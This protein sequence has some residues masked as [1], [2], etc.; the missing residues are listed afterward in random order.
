MTEQERI[1]ELWN[2]ISDDCA[3]KPEDEC[4]VTTNCSECKAI[5]L[6]KAGYVKLQD[7]EMIITKEEYERYNQTMNP[8]KIRKEVA[9]EIYQKLCGHGTTYVKKWIEKE[10]GME[11]K[12]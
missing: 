12:E 2:F 10:F 1:E 5:A 6:V 8:K 11:V 4:V 9:T 3:N 7:H